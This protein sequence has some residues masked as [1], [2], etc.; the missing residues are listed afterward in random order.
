MTSDDRKQVNEGVLQ[1]TGKKTLKKKS[2]DDYADT[3]RFI[4]TDAIKII[5]IEVLNR[6]FFLVQSKD[7]L[8]SRPSRRLFDHTD[9]SGDALE[10]R[11]VPLKY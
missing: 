3:I 7:L 6:C 9:C 8:Y 2:L 4:N 10:Q 1:M 5:N 11:S